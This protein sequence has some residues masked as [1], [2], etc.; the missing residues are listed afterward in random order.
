MAYL[1]VVQR[2]LNLVGAGIAI[3][4][5]AAGVLVTAFAND[6]ATGAILMI[7]GVAFYSFGSTDY[8]D[9]WRVNRVG[10]NVIGTEVSMTST[11]RASPARTPWVPAASL[12]RRDE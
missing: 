5:I 6:T 9:R 1:R 8:F 12:E 7:V 11:S 10:R 4:R 3:A 2:N